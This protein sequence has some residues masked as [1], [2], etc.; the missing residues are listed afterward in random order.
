MGPDYAHGHA[1]R[2]LGFVFVWLSFDRTMESVAVDRGATDN[3][4]IEGNVKALGSG[5]GFDAWENGAASAVSAAVSREQAPLEPTTTMLINCLHVT[6]LSL[7]SVFQAIEE[8]ASSHHRC[9]P[10]HCALIDSAQR[11]RRY[12]ETRFHCDSHRC[13]SNAG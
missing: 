4:H 2:C 5:F 11:E 9:K 10:N 7:W 1:C 8:Q 3:I 13:C 6:S 12:R